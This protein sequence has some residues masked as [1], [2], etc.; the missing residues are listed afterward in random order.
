MQCNKS[1]T[2]HRISAGEQRKGRSE[3]KRF[4]VPHFLATQYLHTK[5]I[6][7]QY[8]NGIVSSASFVST[9]NTATRVR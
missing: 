3:A 7:P 8:P 4:G 1:A 5:G 2:H 6:K 9:P